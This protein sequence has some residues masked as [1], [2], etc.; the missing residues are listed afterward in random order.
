LHLQI[1]PFL[2]YLTLIECTSPQCDD[3]HELARLSGSDHVP[4]DY[5]SR[6]GYMLIQFISYSIQNHGHFV[7]E[8]RTG[9]L[10]SSPKEIGQSLAGM[11][12][13]THFH[14]TFAH[15]RNGGLEY[16]SRVLKRLANL[17]QACVPLHIFTRHLHICGMEDW[18]VLQAISCRHACPHTC[19]HVCMSYS[20]AHMNETCT[21]MNETC[22]DWSLLQPIS[23][24]DGVATVSRID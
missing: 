15:L 21:H 8:W 17:L 1:E 7:A 9:V 2:Q 10:E 3:R 19:A 12:A 4:Q 14:A 24:G 22:Q 16:L 5:T 23:C 11:C 18:S 13:L 6:T 20:S